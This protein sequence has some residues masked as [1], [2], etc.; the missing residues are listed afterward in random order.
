VPHARVKRLFLV[1]V[2]VVGSVL[3]LLFA[4]ARRR[5]RAEPDAHRRFFTALSAPPRPLAVHWTRPGIARPLGG[6]F[7]FLSAT[8]LAMGPYLWITAVVVPSRVQPFPD[9]D[10][11]WAPVEEL[12]T[13]G[14]SI[15]DLGM[16]VAFVQRFA[17][18][19]VG[20][21]ARALRSAQLWIWWEL[22]TGFVL[23]T[24]GGSLACFAL[25]HTRYALFSRV[26][27][28][29]C[30]MQIP[31]VLSVFT[32]FFQ[33]AQRFDYQLGLDLL[34]KRLLFVAVPVPF[35]LLGRALG[36]A[37]PNEVGEAFGA[38]LGIATGQ[39]TALLCTFAIG[40]TLF[41]RLGLPLGP[42]VQAG[43]GRRTFV[44]LARFGVAVVAGKAPFF[45]A[46]ATEIA[47]VTALLPGYPAWLGIRQLLVS[48]LVFTLYFLLPF[49][50]SG[51]PS[52]SEAFAAR[53]LALARY[54]VV[55][56]LQFGHLFVAL[57]VAL[58]VGAGRPLV[59]Y[60]LPVQ[61]HPAATWLP[62]AAVSGLLL[63]AAWT[64]DALQKGAGRAGLDAAILAGEQIV[65][66]AL[67][68]L[69]LP[70]LGFAALFVAVLGA[71]VLKCAVAWTINHLVILR[72][73][74]RFWSS[75]AAPLVAGALWLGT[76]LGLAAALPPTSVA[77]VG[78]FVAA[79]AL[80][81]PAGFFLC[82]LIGGFDPAAQAE[83]VDAAEL[84][85]V[86]KP[87]ARLL[88]R[89]ARAG[90]RLSPIRRSLPPLAAEAAREA[91]EIAAL[92]K[93]TV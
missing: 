7:L 43:F 77:V 59:R 64:S 8:L 6:F 61:W 80:T 5:A 16:T 56:Y 52:F 63:P 93:R 88:A 76:L 23:F 54:Y 62:L 18:H 36:R 44:D 74:L 12:A 40:F 2:V 45:I 11:A 13:L 81:F 78:L 66:L 37:H 17:E 71:L 48:R 3:A 58:L 28:I 22:L 38:L 70:R 15:V 75:V 10:G 42:L 41:R 68:W 19:R 86:M 32:T 91:D 31:G 30:A 1:A 27:L 83:V 46:N 51:V 20:D 53:K 87:I 69:L 92:E 9:V 65:R 21:P 35:V 25:P 79:A 26:V 33:A 14:W 82:G 90:A 4:L 55:R 39:Y 84:A 47:I 85:S 72:I 57:V 60:A 49:T 50:D 29:R 67:V 34:E 89:A 24:V 73:E